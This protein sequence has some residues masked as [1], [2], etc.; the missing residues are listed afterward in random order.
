MDRFFAT[1]CGKY[2]TCQVMILMKYERIFFAFLGETFF[3]L[4]NFSHIFSTFDSEL[5][6][7]DDSLIMSA[8]SAAVYKC[9]IRKVYKCGIKKVPAED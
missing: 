1:A 7:N 4:Q 8:F 5:A 9:G 3:L 2:E 6:E